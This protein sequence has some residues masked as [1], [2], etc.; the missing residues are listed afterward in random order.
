MPSSEL[1]IPDL[2]VIGDITVAYGADGMASTPTALRPLEFV[3][4][5]VVIDSD[6]LEQELP[7]RQGSTGEPPPIL[8]PKTLIGAGSDPVT[9]QSLNFP[10]VHNKPSA[11]EEIE[12]GV[13][14]ENISLSYDSSNKQI[15][16]RFEIPQTPETHED[17]DS[18]TDRDVLFDGPV[19][20]VD[21]FI[22]ELG[23]RRILKTL[24]LSTIYLRG[25]NKDK[26]PGVL[27]QNAYQK[28]ILWDGTDDFGVVLGAGTYLL[29][30][31][32]FRPNEFSVD[33]FGNISISAEQAN[34]GSTSRYSY[35]F[36][37]I[38]HT[39]LYITADASEDTDYIDVYSSYGD[40]RQNYF[41]VA[42]ME[43]DNTTALIYEFPHPSENFPEILTY[44]S[45][46]VEYIAR[47]DFRTY[48]VE[49]SSNR[50]YISHYE[51]GTG[52][53]LFYNYT[54]FIDLDLGDGFITGLAFLRE[55]NLI[56]YASNQI[57]IVSTDALAELHTVID[58][59]KPNDERGER[60]GCAAPGSIVDM[61]GYHLFF[62]T[63][64]YVYMF[65]GQRLMEISEPVH[66]IFQQQAL[67]IS[68]TG[69]IEVE[70]DV[71]GV[72]Y[73]KHYVL[74]LAEMTMVFDT[75]HRVWWQDSYK[76]TKAIREDNGRVYVEI[77]GSP[78]LLFSGDDDNGEVI[79]REYK[80]NPYFQ[81]SHS[82]W[83]SVHVYA[84]GEA[85]IDVVCETEQG[86]VEGT[87]DVVSAGDWFS[88][89][90]GVNLQGRWYTV[91]LET[92]SDVAIDRIMVNERPGK[93][94]GR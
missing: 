38:E 30:F 12:G 49:A 86:E 24:R 29:G 32:E 53:R 88:Q 34:A 79:H 73:D 10:I 16:I 78:Y 92:D 85:E 62:A 35:F 94:R 47:N 40:T 75:V 31:R 82:Q 9:V 3:F 77:D 87:L 67:G 43:A 25:G 17:G 21:I 33:G 50:L 6:A 36:F 71:V 64:R 93:V 7:D 89:R 22:A 83:D 91:E 90:L 70:D 65:D 14:V 76:F 37:D 57:Q 84:Q 23:S 39:I 59:I 44:E 20:K 26:R 48:A 11:D 81:R 2:P 18:N 56:I 42:R 15:K 28:E 66:G 69:A 45:P 68:D 1:E 5:P 63:N 19:G 51:P 4:Q 60:V 55:T 80:S 52:E 61:G 72:A 41:W 74:S 46:D 8:S 27:D 54:N 58:Y 13:P